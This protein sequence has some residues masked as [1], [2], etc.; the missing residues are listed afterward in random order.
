MPFSSE[1]IDAFFSYASASTAHPGEETG[2]SLLWGFMDNAVRI[3][4][5]RNSISNR[6]FKRRGGLTLRACMY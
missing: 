6:R 4:G 1:R 3:C 5:R 2:S